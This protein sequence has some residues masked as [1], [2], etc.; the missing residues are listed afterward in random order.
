[1]LPYW[2]LF[3]FLSLGACLYAWGSRVA[4][5][6]GGASIA[7]TP[8]DALFAFGMLII[9]LMIGLRFEVGGDW[10]TY[11]GIFNVIKR[12]ALAS[13]IEL[14]GQEWGYTVV[15]WLVAYVGGGMWL[16]NLVC[17]VPFGLGLG[18]ICRQQPNPWLALV[19]ATPLFIVVVGMGYT[20]QA[21][22]VG[23]L[24]IGLARVAKGRSYWA[25]LPWPIAGFLFHQTVL[26]FAPLVALIYYR[27][28]AGM[29]A[30]A[31]VAIVIAYFTVLPT[32]L[33]RYQAGY[34]KNIYVAQGAIY[35]L[36]LDA[37]A[38]VVMLAM[39][40]RLGANPAE[41]M[42]WSAW[43]YMSVFSLILYYMIESTIIVDRL[44]IYLMPLQIFVFSRVP[45]AIGKGRLDKLWWTV[46]VS[47]GSGAMLY[48]WLTFANHA[49]FWIPYQ[50]YPIY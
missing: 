11:L 15:N 34:I 43:A 2:L 26:L 8:S 39:R 31:L 35:R 32:A 46:A 24:M 16:V 17:A 22:A 5:A 1:M 9:V 20:R 10:Q 38:G 7:R 50:L 14:S 6:P 25:F 28:R 3:I 33:D 23:L 18:A 49:K 48:V 30:L 40:R 12:R 41:L 4:V 21:T 37:V 45:Q 42:L 13:A 27:K 36:A 47:L 19:V 29:L 44:A